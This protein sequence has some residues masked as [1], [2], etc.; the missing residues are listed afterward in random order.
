MEE[1]QTRIYSSRLQNHASGMKVIFGM[2][3]SKFVKWRFG[4]RVETFFSV[5]NHWGCSTTL[6]V[7]PWPMTLKNRFT[8]GAETSRS[9]S[10]DPEHWLLMQFMPLTTQFKSMTRI[11]TRTEFV[12]NFEKRSSVYFVMSWCWILMQFNSIDS[13]YDFSTY[14]NSQ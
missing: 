4:E 12:Q 2:E 1:P 6:G 9:D 10:G 3:M 8:A 13:L 5:R 14:P 7:Q 11:R